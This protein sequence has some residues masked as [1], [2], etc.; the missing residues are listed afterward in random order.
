MDIQNFLK[1]ELY[2]IIP[3]D[4]RNL[5]AEWMGIIHGLGVLQKRNDQ[6]HLLFTHQDIAL[7]KKIITV[8]KKVQ[9]SSLGYQILALDRRGLN[10]GKFYQVDF[11]LGREWEKLEVDLKCS[12][13]NLHEGGFHFLRGLFEAG[14]YFGEPHKSYQLEIRL[15]SE[16]ICDRV[17]EFLRKQ[18]LDFKK[19]FYRNRFILYSK[20]ISTIASFVH[21]VGAIRTYLM[22]E[23]L[24]AEKATFNEL[25]R[26]VNCE[27]SNLERTV[28]YSIRL[29][30][31]LQRIDL[32]TLPP[33]LL[34]IALL[35]M[36]HPLASL[37]E[38]GKLCKPPI[39]KGEAYRRLRTIEELV[40]SKSLHIKR[41]IL[42]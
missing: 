8:Q 12:I 33:K 2:S 41:D 7:I 25:T 28:A 6:F 23:K 10:R 5:E 40:E 22:L 37:K 17:L 32:E 21:F 30:E 42:Q 29:R 3:D 14:G 20:N 24:V 9:G 38:L 27:T 16:E 35:R 36:R 11:E 31:K 4:I 1:E 39:S 18:N 13:D 34:E 19:R 26:W 15:T